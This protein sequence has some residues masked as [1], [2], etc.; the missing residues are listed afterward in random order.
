MEL[1]VVT[2]RVKPMRCAIEA[3]PTLTEEIRIAKA[4]D[5]QLEQIRKEV[6]LGKALEFVINEDCSLRFHNQVYVPEV[7]MIRNKILE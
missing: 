1:N 3:Q 4:T 6:L 5:P 7:E 2:P